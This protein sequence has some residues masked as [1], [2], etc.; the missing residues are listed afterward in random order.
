MWRVSNQPAVSRKK[1]RK[2][3]KKT[4]MKGM[5]VL[6]VLFVV[7]A[8]ATGVQAQDAVT[9][10]NHRS[11]RCYWSRC[12]TRFG[13]NWYW[14]EPGSNRC[15]SC[16]NDRRGQISN[17]SRNFDDCSSRDNCSV[18]FPCNVRYA[19]SSLIANAKKLNFE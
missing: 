12:G 19:R 18:R 8:F 4:A 13:S 14:Y 1:W 9:M 5:S 10:R 16:R 3:M 11:L 7:A 6:F 17:W 15:C 2:K